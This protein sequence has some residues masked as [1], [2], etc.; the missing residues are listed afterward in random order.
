[1][2]YNSYKLEF[3]TILFIAILFLIL[4]FGEQR[5]FHLGPGRILMLSLGP[6]RSMAEMI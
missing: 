1:L 5:D 4:V 6:V 2:L 3:D